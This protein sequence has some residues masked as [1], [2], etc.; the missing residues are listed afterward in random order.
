MILGLLLAIK[1]VQRHCEHQP[2]DA[3][4]GERPGH[5]GP[6]ASLAPPPNRLALL[7][8]EQL[9]VHVDKHLVDHV[10]HVLFV[11][12]QESQ[13]LGHGL[14]MILAGGGGDWR[15]CGGGGGRA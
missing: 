7:I 2:A 14:L 5:T 4:N 11:G 3:G 15:A 1:T 8:L 13:D 10:R 6:R 12:Q 9:H